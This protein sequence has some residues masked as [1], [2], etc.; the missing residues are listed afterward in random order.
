MPSIYTFAALKFLRL[1]N[2]RAIPH[3]ITERHC[4][5]VDTILT[6]EGEGTIRAQILIMSRCVRSFYEYFVLGHISIH[7][8]TVTVH[9]IIIP[10]R[11]APVHPAVSSGQ[12]HKGQ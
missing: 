2:S 9:L 4:L 1:K 12:P 8:T 5:N 7:L 11:P 6:L 3:I 10:A